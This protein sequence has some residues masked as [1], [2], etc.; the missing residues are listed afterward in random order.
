VSR[1]PRETRDILLRHERRR[2]HERARA[3]TARHAPKSDGVIDGGSQRAEAD[4][5]EEPRREV[6]RVCI[7]CDSRRDREDGED[8]AQREQTR[9]REATPYDAY[10]FA[11][12]H[13]HRAD[14]HCISERKTRRRARR[15]VTPTTSRRLEVVTFSST[16]RVKLYAS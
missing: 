5:D 6:D 3:S 11:P 15:R 10:S 7:E 12:A 14:A 1:P 2:A 16:M 9:A 13:P 8:D 4:E